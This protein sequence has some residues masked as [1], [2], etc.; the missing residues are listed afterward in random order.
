MVIAVSQHKVD[1]NAQQHDRASGWQTIGFGLG[2]IDNKGNTGFGNRL[3]AQDAHAP[4]LD[5]SEQRWR[6]TRDNPLATQRNF[7]LVIRH[8]I[9][10]K[11]QQLQCQCGFSGTRRA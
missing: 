8:Q 5:H 11:G 10:A 3:G 2:K 7:G 1:R 4:R 6:A 9:G